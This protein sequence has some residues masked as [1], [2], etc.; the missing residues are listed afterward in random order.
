MNHII[1]RGNSRDDDRMREAACSLTHYCNHE[2]IMVIYA[3]FGS[4]DFWIKKGVPEMY[5][6]DYTDTNMKELMDKIIKCKNSYKF[7]II[8]DN[9]F[10]KELKEFGGRYISIEIDK[11]IHN[12]TQIPDIPSVPTVKISK[13][14]V[15]L[16]LLLQKDYY[17]N[18][19]NISN[20][21]I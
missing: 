16:A 11:K 18:S 2:I 15:E 17:D 7:L 21:F 1:I 8:F 9:V 6:H 19:K 14:Q 10:I 13:K 12:T 3:N 5:C 4:R 20:P